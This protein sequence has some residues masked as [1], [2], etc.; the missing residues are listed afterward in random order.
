MQLCT[1]GCK[2]TVYLKSLEAL[3][4]F[5]FRDIISLIKLGGQRNVLYSYEFVVPMATIVSAF[6]GS[7]IH[8]M[9]GK[10]ADEFSVFL[11]CLFFPTFFHILP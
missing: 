6:G 3:N 2:N 1:N 5:L 10:S 8:V 11:F 9:T 4:S 7:T